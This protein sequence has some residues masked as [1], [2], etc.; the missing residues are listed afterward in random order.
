MSP[1]SDEERQRRLANFEK[2]QAAL[3]ARREAARRRDREVSDTQAAVLGKR[4]GLGRFWAGVAL[5]LVL[6]PLSWLASGTVGRYT[7]NDFGD[8]KTTYRAVV[9]SCDKRGPVTDKGGF[10]TYYVCRVKIGDVDTRQIS[11]PGFFP[12][13]QTGRTIT[14]GDNG[15]SR[16]VHAWSRPELPSRWY[17]NALVIILGLFPALVIC[18]LVFVAIAA[19][20]GRRRKP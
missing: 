10:G 8:A 15:S 9:Q 5:V 7:G 3:D 11:D 18:L 13:D 6:A 2:E 17:L 14:I 19:F 4:S 1:M 12:D 20:K 16:G